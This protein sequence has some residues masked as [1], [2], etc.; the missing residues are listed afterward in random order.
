M[1]LV[2]AWILGPS[3]VSVVSATINVMD[4]L[5]GL[6]RD[7]IDAPTIHESSGSWFWLHSCGIAGGYY[8]SE[9]ETQLSAAG[10]LTGCAGAIISPIRF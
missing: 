10:H 2:L 4:I 9:A 1:F 8:E 3:I 6:D 5:D 7:A